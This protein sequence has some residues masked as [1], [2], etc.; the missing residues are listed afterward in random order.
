LKVTL[1][2]LETHFAPLSES[3]N[4]GRLRDAAF[5]DE[6]EC[7]A[8]HPIVIFARTKLRPCHQ[9]ES[10]AGKRLVEKETKESDTEQA[11]FFI[12]D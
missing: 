11:S 3:N 10:G 4:R 5:V 8:D 12:I 7:V 6:Y 1:P 2:Y 9:A